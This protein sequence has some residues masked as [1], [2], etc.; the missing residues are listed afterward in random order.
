MYMYNNII[1]QEILLISRLLTKMR[2]FENLILVRYL[3][4]KI[5]S[6]VVI[7]SLNV[8]LLGS[9][10]LYFLFLLY[11]LKNAR[12]NGISIGWA[13]CYSK[14]KISS[15]IIYRLKILPFFFFFFFIWWATALI[16]SK[17]KLQPS[18]PIQKIQNYPCYIIFCSKN[19]RCMN[20]KKTAVL[21]LES[22]T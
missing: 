12:K 6:R 10:Q 2:P 8:L 7:L 17:R 9:T 13:S 18:T 16:S 5:I 14:L 20:K 21:A 19:I 11:I 1:S 22:P 15:L 4:Y 3:H